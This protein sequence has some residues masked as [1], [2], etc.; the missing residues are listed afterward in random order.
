MLVQV[1]RVR[2]QT[3][4]IKVDDDSSNPVE[5]ALDKIR[6]LAKEPSLVEEY[7]TFKYD[8]IKRED[9]A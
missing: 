5:E 3:Y 9:K 2:V 4:L 6:I 7:E 1:R 8:R